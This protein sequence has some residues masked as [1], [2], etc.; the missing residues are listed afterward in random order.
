M[1]RLPV[2]LE[3]EVKGLWFWLEGL[4][5]EGRWV[6]DSSLRIYLDAV[7]TSAMAV[8]ESAA[9][10]SGPSRP[11]RCASPRGDW[12][13]PLPALELPLPGALPFCQT[14][15]ALLPPPW[16]SIDRCGVDRSEPG[17]GLKGGSGDC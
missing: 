15:P 3:M 10:L 14:R 9:A 1:R 7:A 4:R 8:S 13:F 2:N 12:R 5:E 16:W 11:L 6:A 17:L